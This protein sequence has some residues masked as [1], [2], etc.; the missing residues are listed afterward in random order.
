M[1]STNDRN[2]EK[3]ELTSHMDTLKLSA[4]V[5]SQIDRRGKVFST[6]TFPSQK[7]SIN[8][9]NPGITVNIPKFL[10]KFLRIFFGLYNI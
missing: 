2:Q 7:C 6:G 9:K 10:I 1:Y 8:N 5:V 3:G 4:N